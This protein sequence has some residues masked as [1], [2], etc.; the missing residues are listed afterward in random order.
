MKK[1][2]LSITLS[3]ALAAGLNAQSL[4]TQMEAHISMSTP[5]LNLYFLDLGF[6]DL[7]LAHGSVG[8]MNNPGG[9]GRTGIMDVTVAGSLS[10][11]ASMS[12][13]IRL[14]DST[15]VTGELNIPTYLTLTDQGGLDYVG[16]AG[17]MGPFG[18]GIAYQRSFAVEAGLDKADMD[19]SQRFNYA[20]D[21]IL[22]SDAN[23]LLPGGL[24]VPVTFNVSAVTNVRL[25]GSGEARISNQPIFVGA[26]TKY[27]PINMGMGFKVTRIE[28]LAN[29]SL[30]L[31]GSI[32]SLRGELDSANYGGPS[33]IFDNVDIYAPFGDSIFY[34]KFSSDLQGTQYSLVLGG[35]MELPIVK[36]GMSLEMGMPYKLSGY[37][38]NNS[39]LP[40]GQPLLDSI[41]VSSLQYD[42]ASQ[43]FTG[44]VK[45]NLGGVEYTRKTA[46]DTGEIEL[47]GV[48]SLKASLG[49]KLW[50]LRVGVNGGM[51]M[52]T[53][54]WP[55]IGNAYASLGTSLSI[56]RTSLRLGLA[57]RWQYLAL[58]DDKLY[59]SAPMVILGAGVGIPFP[60][61]ELM[62]GS[63]IN[64]ANGILSTS[65][66][67]KME[68]FKPWETIALNAGIRVSI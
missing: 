58:E 16:V 44:D 4:A 1:T 60:K 36:L 65:N 37:Y 68:D 28:A 11:D 26:G 3:L 61:G 51:D 7:N 2:L 22:T 62:L 12:T 38:F 31:S 57:S 48:T 14:M 18:V 17:K 30:K 35:N 43:T 21:Y 39:G 32:D 41:S 23:G 25:K 34:S 10:K 64:L 50:G 67:E 59:S 9:L 40:E 29:T 56:K 27:G 20:Y 42:S 49:L 47:P 24:A 33:V 8:M 5:E 19:I 13:D 63:R 55:M 52:M 53:G 46:A 54:E 45:L 6:L 66:L 15:E